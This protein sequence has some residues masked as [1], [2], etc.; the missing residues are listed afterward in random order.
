LTEAGSRGTDINGLFAWIDNYCA[1]H[2]IDNI[3]TATSR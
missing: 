3:A 1:T 2:P